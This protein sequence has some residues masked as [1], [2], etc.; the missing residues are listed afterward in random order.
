[1]ESE[2]FIMTSLRSM[3]SRSLETGCYGSYIASCLGA[4]RLSGSRFSSQQNPVWV[5]DQSPDDLSSQREPALVRFKQC[6]RFWGERTWTVWE[7]VWIV[8]QTQ[9]E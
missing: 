8:K 5:L 3:L 6:K 2:V 1:M 7:K 4:R 9:G